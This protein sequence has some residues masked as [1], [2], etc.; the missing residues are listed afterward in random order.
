MEDDYDS[1]FR[2]V[3]RPLAALQGID[4][5]GRVIYVGTFSKVL[6]PSLRIG[7]LILPPPMVNAFLTAR[8][9]VDVHTPILEQR[10]L[11]DFIVEGHFRRHLRRMR[12]IYAERR[13][14]L[15]EAA[16]SMPLEIHGPEAGFHC[17]G[18]LPEGMDDLAL[19]RKAAAQG[20][21]LWTVSDFS[22][23]PQT[24]KGLVLG[25]GDYNVKQI[26][27]GMRRLAAAMRSV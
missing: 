15:L 22:I 7:Y 27:E 5:A 23:E 3:G 1:E 20:L 19:V 2:F 21:E 14:A 17:I 24:R 9:L 10:A 26:R 8:A 4:D 18:Y 12:I 25:Y 13:A 6:F 16:R 11:A